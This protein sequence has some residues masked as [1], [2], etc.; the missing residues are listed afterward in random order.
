MIE[1]RPL[2]VPHG[3]SLGGLLLLANGIA[4]QAVAQ[5]APAAEF[6]QVS[7]GLY[8]NYDFAGSNS[9]VLITDEGVLVVD[10]R[11]HPVGDRKVGQGARVRL[12][13]DSGLSARRAELRLRSRNAPG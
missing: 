12:P 10:T 4:F 8:F 7:P 3:F 5:E 1:T 2:L 6:L 9:A 11:T 13:L